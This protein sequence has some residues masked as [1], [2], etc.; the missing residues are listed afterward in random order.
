MASSGFDQTVRLWDVQRG[1][2]HY[3]LP[4]QT[5]AIFSLAFHPNGELLAVGSEDHTIQ[6]WHIG[7]V[8]ESMSGVPRLLRTLRGHTDVVEAVRFGPDGRWL[9]SSSGDETIRLW[10]VA[11]GPGLSTLRA[12][13][14]YAGMNITGVTG[15]ST[16]Q[17][18]A[19]KALGAVDGLGEL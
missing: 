2:A 14:P 10:D 11:T 16:A 5:A 6:L 12:D 9:A 3:S 1:Q 4:A 7:P 15:I 13:G 17:T 18:T 19:L 8:S